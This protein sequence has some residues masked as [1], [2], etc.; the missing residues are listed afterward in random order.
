MYVD[1]LDI[2]ALRAARVCP[3]IGLEGRTVFRH[4]EAFGRADRVL[5]T[6]LSIDLTVPS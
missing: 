3:H 4:C 1:N 2:S 5:F 6:L